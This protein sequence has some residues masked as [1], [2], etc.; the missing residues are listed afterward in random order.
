MEREGHR[1]EL[2]NIFK[3]ALSGDR[4]KYDIL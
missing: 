4:A 3:K 2:L 1:R